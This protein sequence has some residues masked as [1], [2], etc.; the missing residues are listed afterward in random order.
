MAYRFIECVSKDPVLEQKRTC[1][2]ICKRFRVTKPTGV[3]RYESGQG[4][5]HTCDVWLDYRGCHV[6]DGS[7]AKI[8]SVG[9]FCNCC[10]FRVTQS[11]TAPRR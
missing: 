9:W 8:G 6:K 3:G 2:G 4:R 1:R 7:P 10:N 5:C 11:S